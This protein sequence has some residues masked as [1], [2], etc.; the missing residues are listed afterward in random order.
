VG[1]N[2]G[3]SEPVVLLDHGLHPVCR[4]YFEGGPL[5]RRRERMGVLSHVQ[6]T[7]RSLTPTEFADRLCNGKDVGLVERA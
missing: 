5:R 6:G 2:G 3:G 7:A 4:E 1:D